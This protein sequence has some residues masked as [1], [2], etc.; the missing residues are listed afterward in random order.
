MCKCPIQ[1]FVSFSVLEQKSSPKNDRNCSSQKKILEARKNNRQ[2]ETERERE[3]EKERGAQTSR[4]DRERERR[5]DKTRR[6]KGTETLFF[7]RFSIRF[8]DFFFFVVMKN[9]ISSSFHRL[10]IALYMLFQDEVSRCGCADLSLV[11]FHIRTQKHAEKAS[12]GC[13]EARRRGGESERAGR[14]A[15]KCRG[16]SVSQRY[17]IITRVVS[18]R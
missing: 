6:R 15:E 10:F 9:I 7:P 13:G 18:L 4:R 17:E 5:D 8:L 11:F 14:A 2:R 1:N 3:R 16:D 12:G